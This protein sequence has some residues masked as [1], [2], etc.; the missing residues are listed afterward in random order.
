VPNTS[1]QWERIKRDRI[2]NAHLHQIGLERL[3]APRLSKT[4][5]VIFFGQK[6]CS[7]CG[8]CKPVESFSKRSGRNHPNSECLVCQAKRREKDHDRNLATSRA[9][10]QNNREAVRQRHAVY[11]AN[12]REAQAERVKDWNKRNR[13]RVK[14]YAKKFRQTAKGKAAMARVY[15]NRRARMRNA[16]VESVDPEWLLILQDWTCHICGH[17][18]AGIDHRASEAATDDHL[19]PISLGG[20]HEW[21]NVLESHRVCNS[22]KKAFRVDKWIHPAWVGF[23]AFV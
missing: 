22:R 19:R 12:N 5:P 18:M 13:P 2:E 4:I 10:Y 1:E 8:V 17:Y 23:S 3:F 16:F 14:A 9:Y 6:V 15:R 21:R 7:Q 20:K 11:L